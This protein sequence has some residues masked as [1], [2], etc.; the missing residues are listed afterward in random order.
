[1][2]RKV[3][4]HTESDASKVLSAMRLV[5]WHQTPV[6]HRETLLEHHGMTAQILLLID[7]MPRAALLAVAVTHDIGEAKTGDIASPVKDSLGIRYILDGVEATANP[8]S[9]CVYKLSKDEKILLHI[10]DTMA[11]AAYLLFEV[12]MGN[13]LVLPKLEKAIKDAVALIEGSIHKKKAVKVL[14]EILD[15]FPLKY[16]QEAI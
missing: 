10:V 5:R 2:A 1:M 6:L 16:A 12:S 9:G 7:P 3:K 13:T 11:R 14:A 8:F 15:Y 4:P